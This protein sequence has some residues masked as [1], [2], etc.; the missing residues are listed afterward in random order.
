MCCLVSQAQVVAVI[1]AV[2]VAVF[3]K[4][5]LMC[6]FSVKNISEKK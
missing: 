1:P 5:F 6:M 4:Y 2:T 3:A